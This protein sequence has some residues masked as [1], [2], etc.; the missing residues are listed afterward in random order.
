MRLYYRARTREARRRP[1]TEAEA[2]AWRQRIFAETMEDPA[3]KMAAP[4][5]GEVINRGGSY[6]QAPASSSKKAE[7][8]K[9]ESP[10]SPPIEKKGRVNLTV[11]VERPQS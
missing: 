8:E 1:F 5:D 10:P 9:R 7:G 2:A 4:H 11:A 6:Q 3:A